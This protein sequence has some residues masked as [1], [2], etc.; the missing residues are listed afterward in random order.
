MLPITNVVP[1]T[2]SEITYGPATSLGYKPVSYARYVRNR[3]RQKPPF[4]L[5]LPSGVNW[6]YRTAPGNIT[7]P[8]YVDALQLRTPGDLLYRHA[9]NKAYARLQDDI[10]SS[11]SQLGANLGEL[12]KTID[13]INNRIQSIYQFTKAQLRKKSRK[14]KKGRPRYKTPAEVFIEYRWVY[15]ATAKDIYNAVDFVQN[16]SPKTYVSGSGTAFETGSQTSRSD[17]NGVQIYDFQFTRESARARICSLVSVSNPN[18]FW[19]SQMG[20]TN[21]AG[22]AWELLKFSWLADWFGT[23][24]EVINSWD[25]RLGLSFSNPCYVD[26]RNLKSGQAYF[27]SWNRNPKETFVKNW[28]G[29]TIHFTRVDSLGPGPYLLVRQIKAPSLVRGATAIALLTQ[30][31]G[32][33]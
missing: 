27:F 9:Y 6:V 33:K 1:A 12:G 13:T 3:K 21:P 17:V 8:S 26:F 11:T 28:T 19:A 7:S 20:L 4:N 10:N 18:L 2:K 30:L 5:V 24:G 23:L 14:S 29:N 15:E 16:F 31:L 25:D 32:R 22:I